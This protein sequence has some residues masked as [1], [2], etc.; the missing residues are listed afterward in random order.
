MTCK[1]IVINS[2]H[3]FGAEL[4]RAIKQKNKIAM[5]LKDLYT[6]HLCL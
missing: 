6:T 5:E 1:T 4:G 2:T 3:E